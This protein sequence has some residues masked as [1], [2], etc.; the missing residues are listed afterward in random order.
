MCYKNIKL[1]M[2]ILYINKVEKENY[3][4]SLYFIGVLLLIIIKVYKFVLYKIVCFSIIKIVL[5]C[6][7][8]YY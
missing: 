6:I 5:N 3:G 1:S 7:F 4:L 8:F 2:D